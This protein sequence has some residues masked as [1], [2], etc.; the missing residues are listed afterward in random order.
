MSE[1]SL[2]ELD[3]AKELDDGDPARLAEV[4]TEVWDLLPGLRVIGGCCGTD[5]RHV[6]AM[7]GV[8]APVA[9]QW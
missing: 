3:E 7:W 9:T 1:L 6:S 2:A 5:A 4:R 8:D